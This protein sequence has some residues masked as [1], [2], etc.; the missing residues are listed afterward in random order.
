MAALEK[1]KMEVV[2]AVDAVSSRVDN[3]DGGVRNAGFTT[4]SRDALASIGIDDD[5]DDDD[6][7]S[8]LVD[9]SGVAEN[10]TRVD[11]DV[12]ADRRKALTDFSRAICH[13]ERLI[14]QDKKNADT[15]RVYADDED[16]TP[17]PPSNDTAISVPLLQSQSGL[18]SLPD[19]GMMFSHQLLMHAFSTLDE[20]ISVS[21]P[22]V[23][24]DT[25]PEEDI[26]SEF[27]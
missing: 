22:I 1:Q 26:V 23:G 15:S 12:A 13:S 19:V 21:A 27:K 18:I 10:D 7:N 8:S 2:R 20:D 16:I 3:G 24:D 14:N 5:D 25:T 9:Q 6:I 4:V 11:A 17:L